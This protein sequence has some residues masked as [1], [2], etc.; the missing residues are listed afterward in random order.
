MK[1]FSRVGIQGVGELFVKVDSERDR[2][3]RQNG[4]NIDFL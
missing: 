2:N 4:G 3:V 1:R